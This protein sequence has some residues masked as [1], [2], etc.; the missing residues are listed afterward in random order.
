MAMEN[1]SSESSHLLA[2]GS[3]GAAADYA[4]A[5]GSPQQSSEA[6]AKDETESTKVDTLAR[7]NN[8][9]VLWCTI[10]VISIVTA[11]LA[12][13]AVLVPGLSLTH[14]AFGFALAYAAIISANR[15]LVRFSW[16]NHLC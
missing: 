14:G 15:F 9:F 7:A 10:V 6:K 13:A 5:V 4:T 1:E 3:R 11:A 12:V 2:G 8:R 16:G